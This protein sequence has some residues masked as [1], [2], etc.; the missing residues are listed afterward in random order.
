M[1]RTKYLRQ[2]R[3][4]GMTCWL[5]ALCNARRY[6]GL[7]SPRPNTKRWANLC[8]VGGCIGGACMS[9]RHMAREL[10]LKLRRIKPDN[11]VKRHPAVILLF[12]P[13][14]ARVFHAA[15]VVGGNSEALTLVNYRTYLGPTVEAV[16]WSDLH[17]PE[18][19][20][21]NRKAWAVRVR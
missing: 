16:P 3:L 21:V 5:F 10:G 18:V 20:N 2:G 8:E 19:G 11:I 9:P 15:L 1:A 4:H 14:P 6:Y 12:T 13:L 7:P 17:L